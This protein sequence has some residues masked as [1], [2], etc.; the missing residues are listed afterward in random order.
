MDTFLS[1]QRDRLNTYFQDIGAL[2]AKATLLENS[3]QLPMHIINHLS[4][5]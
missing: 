4:K 1:K 5:L 2:A 3:A